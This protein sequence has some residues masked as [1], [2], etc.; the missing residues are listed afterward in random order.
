[1]ILDDKLIMYPI[2][3][4][5]NTARDFSLVKG[6]VNLFI[7]FNMQPLQVRTR[8]CKIPGSNPV[9]LG[10]CHDFAPNMTRLTLNS[11]Q[12]KIAIH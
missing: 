12:K 4:Q 10:G 7:G 11:S 6:L 8:D 1:M 2:I 5:L 3:K 9:I